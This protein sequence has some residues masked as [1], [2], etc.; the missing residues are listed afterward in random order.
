MDSDKGKLFIGGI[1]WETDEQ[2]LKEYFQGYGEVLQTVVMRDKLTGKPRGFGFV[3]FADPNILDSVLQDNH[4][5]DNRTITITRRFAPSTTPPQPPPTT[6][7]QPLPSN[8]RVHHTTTHRSATYTLI[9]NN[10]M[11]TTTQSSSTSHHTTATCTT[12]PHTDLP[13]TQRYRSRTIVVSAAH[14]SSDELQCGPWLRQPCIIGD[15]ETE[16]ERGWEEEEK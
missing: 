7:K 6:T 12:P 8:Y 3:V 9:A 13:M 16:R 4:V 1:S 2:K 11:T 5:I 14:C 15:I 10:K